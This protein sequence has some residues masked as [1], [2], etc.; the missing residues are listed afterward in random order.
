MYKYFTLILLCV[1]AC[2]QSPTASEPVSPPQTI[3]DTTFTLNNAPLIVDSVYA[4]TILV[5]YPDTMD[6]QLIAVHNAIGSYRIGITIFRPAMIGSGGHVIVGFIDSLVMYTGVDDFN[7]LSLPP[8]HFAF[9]DTLRVGTK[10]EL[11]TGNE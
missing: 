6:E 11:L 5:H 8:Y 1:C 3:H 4:W 7:I 10:V 9:V 2:N